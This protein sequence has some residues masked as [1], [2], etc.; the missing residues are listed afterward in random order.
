MKEIKTELAKVMFEN[1]VLYTVP[2]EYDHSGIRIESVYVDNNEL[3]KSMWNN[4]NGS[5]RTV[6]IFCQL[7]DKVHISAKLVDLTD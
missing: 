4:A 2:M 5:A 3:P 6:N 1:N 7:N